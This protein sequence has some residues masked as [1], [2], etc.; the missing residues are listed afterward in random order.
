MH[1]DSFYKPFLAANY[2]WL[3]KNFFLLFCKS[4]LY[5]RT[6]LV[7]FKYKDLLYR[8]ES[9]ILTRRRLL[10]LWKHFPMGFMET[11]VVGQGLGYPIKERSAPAKLTPFAKVTQSQR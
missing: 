5:L 8:L 4:I 3:F 7:L 2:K 1:F 10:Q 9:N 6:F 11:E